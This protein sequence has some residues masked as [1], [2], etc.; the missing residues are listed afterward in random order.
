MNDVVNRIATG[1]ATLLTADQICERI[2]VSR[3]TFDRWVRNGEGRASASVSSLA[4]MLD[5]GVN[6]AEGTLRF[7]PPDIRIGNSPRWELETFK[8]W[9][10]LNVKAV[11]K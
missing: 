6:F 9:L 5:A 2:G 8:K 3:S 10:L 11:S 7:P 1:Q 4:A